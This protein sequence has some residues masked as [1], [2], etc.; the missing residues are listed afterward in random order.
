MRNIFLHSLNEINVTIC[1][2]VEKKFLPNGITILILLSESH[3]SLHTYPE[4]NSMF[5]DIFTCGNYNPD[6]AFPFL[7]K[8]LNPKSYNKNVI[9]RK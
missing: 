4:N 1:D 5:L 6:K 7:L 2:I 9:I 3:T 8:E